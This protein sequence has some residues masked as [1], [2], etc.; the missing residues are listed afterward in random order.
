[1]FAAEQ[2]TEVHWQGVCEEFYNIL[3]AISNSR[4]QVILSV[5][6]V[7]NRCYKVALNR[8]CL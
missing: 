2:A 5:L 1:M 8:E 3:Y 6:W 7:A 4:Y